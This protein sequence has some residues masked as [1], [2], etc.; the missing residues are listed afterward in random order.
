MQQDVW[1]HEHS[2]A[3]R[4]ATRPPAGTIAATINFSAAAPII[5]AVAFS[6]LGPDCSDGDLSPDGNL[7]H[8]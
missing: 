8:D 7:R 6:K 1:R 2:G 4:G 3:V 5:A